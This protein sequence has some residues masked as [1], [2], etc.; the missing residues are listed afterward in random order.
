MTPKPTTP[1]HTATIKA[2]MDGSRLVISLLLPDEPKGDMA[3][4]M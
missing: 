1:M 4:R 3:D 2:N